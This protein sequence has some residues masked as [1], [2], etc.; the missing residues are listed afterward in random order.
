MDGSFQQCC[1]KPKAESSKSV[2]DCVKG[3]ILPELEH[4]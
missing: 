1:Q 3:K 2:V 4:Q